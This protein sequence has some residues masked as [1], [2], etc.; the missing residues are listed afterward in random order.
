MEHLDSYLECIKKLSVVSI[1]KKFTIKYYFFGDKPV[2]TIHGYTIDLGTYETRDEAEKAIIELVLKTGHNKFYIHESGKWYTLTTNHDL[3]KNHMGKIDQKGISLLKE[4]YE[5]KVKETDEM[6][7]IKDEIYNNDEF[8][9]Y[10]LLLIQLAETIYKRN[11]MMLN[12]DLSKN[13]EEFNSLT[14]K[15]NELYKNKYKLDKN[16]ESKTKKDGFSDNIKLMIKTMGLSDKI[17]ETYINEIQYDFDIKNDKNYFN[18][19]LTLISY[20]QNTIKYTNNFGPDELIVKIKELNDKISILEPKY[21]KF[22]KTKLY[23]DICKTINNMNIAKTESDVIL[24][25]IKSYYLNKI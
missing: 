22:G 4:N 2:D 8:V 25:Y 9:K 13:E 24:E 10:K 3:M 15:I 7:K 23:N 19:L 1:P 5:S 6:D 12:V 18:Y 21:K 14:T 20:I 16:Y 11:E 17:F